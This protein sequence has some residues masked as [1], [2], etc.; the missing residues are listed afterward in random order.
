MIDDKSYIIDPSTALCKLALLYFMPEGTRI[1]IS[2]HILHI[3]EYSY[4]Q[5]AVRR[6]H[7]DN[8]KD[9]S[10]LHIPLHKASKWYI[11]DTDER[12]IFP[13]DKTTQSFRVSTYY[14]I[15]GLRKTQNTTYADDLCMR[16][17]LQY[18]INMLN[19]ALTNTWSDDLIVK[20]PIDGSILTDTI[21]K[22]YDPQ[23]I[24]TV[25]RMLSGAD[26]PTNIQSNVNAM[27]ECIH[28]LLMNRD[29]EFANLMKEINTT[30]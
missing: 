11:L 7:G 27:V 20:N 9:M 18:F 21:K 12:V 24:S 30:I 19:S 10:N 13:D 8:R 2:H 5:G 26:Q 1:S 3:Q 23:T 29:T 6:I 17:I 25:A 22:N 4:M 14:A 15:K 16:I 28:K